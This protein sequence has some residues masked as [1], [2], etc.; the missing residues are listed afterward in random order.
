MARSGGRTSRYSRK[1]SNT[2]LKICENFIPARTVPLN[3]P[4]NRSKSTVSASR[5]T[6]GSPAHSSRTAVTSLVSSSAIARTSWMI[7]SRRALV[8]A[9][10][11]PKSMKPT[12]CS[13][14]R[15]TLP[16]C[17]S[18]WNSP[19]RMIIRRT[20]F[21]YRLANAATKGSPDTAPST[22]TGFPYSRSCTLTRS[23]VNS[24]WIAGV[25][26]PSVS[27]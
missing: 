17:G 6:L 8:R 16:G 26:I 7:C 25:L 23:P 20:A 19:L 27:R 18:P 2:R 12:S 3:S 10:T 9:P 1:R 24:Q 22:D 13:P 5:S 4:I 21:A 15:K 14:I 11:D